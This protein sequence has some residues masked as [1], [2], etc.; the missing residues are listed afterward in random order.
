MKTYETNTNMVPLMDVGTYWGLFSW[1]SM[2]EWQAK[3]EAEAGRL[4]CDDFD[5]G[6][7]KKAIA[8]CAQ[9]VLDRYT[10][11]PEDDLREIGILRFHVKGIGSPREYNFQTDWLEF[12]IDV[13]DDWLDKS[14]ETLNGFGKDSKERKAIDKYIEDHW[15]SRDGF[16]SSM[17]S[18]LSELQDKVDDLKDGDTYDEIRTVGGIM[19]LLL[20]A[21]GALSR[22]QYDNT[23][24]SED[25][26]EDLLDKFRENYSLDNFCTVVEREDVDKVFKRNYI[27]FDDIE[28]DLRAQYDRYSK[29]MA[30][31]G[32]T[33]PVER[34]QHW[35]QYVRERID[36]WRTRQDEALADYWDKSNKKKYFE[37]VQDIHG[38]KAEFDKEREND[39]PKHWRTEEEEE[40]AWAR[41]LKARAR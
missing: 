28:Q 20:V 8:V 12:D 11:S 5:Y 2:W 36:L 26:T 15:H 21:R 17:P 29:A 3:Q 13:E 23:C 38:I 30:E 37:V 10:E 27:K 6:E 19:A 33:R 40:E 34:A 39:W 22:D 14:M 9:K 35:L 7:M 24:L 41:S 16:I 32:R 1:D 18:S 31:C 4:V 25:L